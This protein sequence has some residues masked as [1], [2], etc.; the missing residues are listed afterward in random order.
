MKNKFIIFSFLL[1]AGLMSACSGDHASNQGKDT[2]GHWTATN[3]YR[4]TFAT[5]NT[6]GEATMTDNS[7]SGGTRIAKMQST[8]Q[9]AA[10]DTVKK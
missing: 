1:S 4:D 6:M 3:P 2:S 9:T 7:G 8:A 10:A 5:T